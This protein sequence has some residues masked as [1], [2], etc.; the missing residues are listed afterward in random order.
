M[1]GNY[2][3]VEVIKMILLLRI[4]RIRG[5]VLEIILLGRL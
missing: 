2:S 1:E 3:Y 4:I 5:F